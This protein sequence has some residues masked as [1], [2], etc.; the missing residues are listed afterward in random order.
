MPP[1]PCLHDRQSNLSGPEQLRI[2][3][4]DAPEANAGAPPG[5]TIGRPPFGNCILPEELETDGHTSR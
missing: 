2:G 3:A 1:P 5:L 4:N